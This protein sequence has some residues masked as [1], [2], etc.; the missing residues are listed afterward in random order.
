MS[1]YFKHIEIPNCDIITSKS[2]EFVKGIDKIYNR[3]LP[4]AS[5]YILDFKK[6][7]DCCPTIMESFAKLDMEPH[8]A[9]IFIM[10]KNNHSPVH[11]D[12]SPPYA[13][14]LIPLLNAENTR[15]IFYQ[16]DNPIEWINPDSGVKS[17]KP[18]K[19]YRA[20]DSIVVK[21]PWIMRTSVPHNTIMNENKY[22]RITMALEFKTDP[23]I[24]LDEL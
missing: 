23:V 2:L 22:P 7:I 24:F 5:Y 14:V 19:N 12:I 18:G 6:L 15:T 10:Y 13:K 9:S 11:A 1:K 8:F 16:D 20:K 3:R 21:G 17:F 4:N